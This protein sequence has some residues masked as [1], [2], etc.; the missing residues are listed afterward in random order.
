MCFFTLESGVSYV[1]LECGVTTD[2]SNIAQN[3]L[4]HSG[5]TGAPGTHAVCSVAT[6]NNNFLTEFGTVVQ[7]TVT[8]A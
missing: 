3:I 4:V 6:A 1:D 7:G 5:A 8:Q 2:S